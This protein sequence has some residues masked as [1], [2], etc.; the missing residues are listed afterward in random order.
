MKKNI[1]NMLKSCIALS[2]SGSSLY[3]LSDIRYRK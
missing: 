2:T 1:Y 3:K